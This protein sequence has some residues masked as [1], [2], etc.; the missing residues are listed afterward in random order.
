MSDWLPLPFE[1]PMPAARPLSVSELTAR[2]KGLVE[3]AFGSVVVEGEIS[4]CKQWSSGHIYFTLKDDYA[5]VRA[6]M[7]RMTAQQ[8][9]F[10]PED[11]MHVSRAA[12]SASTR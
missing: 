2:L 3:G 8:L 5:Q 1:E 12:A 11:G 9:K 7:F 4:N 6:V 10:R